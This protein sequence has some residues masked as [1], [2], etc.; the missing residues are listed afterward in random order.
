MLMVLQQ[1]SARQLVGLLNIQDEN[2]AMK[3]S[4][5]YTHLFFRMPNKFVRN[6]RWRAWAF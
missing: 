2:G 5:R 4:Y 3:D 1:L 6:L